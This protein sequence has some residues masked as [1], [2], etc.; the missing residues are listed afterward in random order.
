M[1]FAIG[2][3]LQPLFWPVL[4]G[5]SL[6]LIRLLFPKTERVLFRMNAFEAIGLL[7]GRICRAC[8]SRRHP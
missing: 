6:W 7:A 1:G 4:L 8:R 3:I 5:V 2:A